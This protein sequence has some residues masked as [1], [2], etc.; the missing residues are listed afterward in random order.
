M[1][2]TGPFLKYAGPVV[3]ACARCGV[4]YVDITGET[5]FVHRSLVMHNE[6]AQKSGAAIV[7]MCGFDRYSFLEKLVLSLME[8]LEAVKVSL[9]RLRKNEEM[10]NSNSFICWGGEMLLN[11]FHYF[12]FCFV[13]LYT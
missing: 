12:F 7:H 13:L 6:V 3:E 9:K 8:P 2:A 1:C 4:D 5:P 11:H 10:S